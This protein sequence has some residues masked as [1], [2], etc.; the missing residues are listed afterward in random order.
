M[1]WRATLSV[2]SSVLCRPIEEQHTATCKEELLVLMVGGLR[3]DYPPW[4][5][6]FCVVPARWRS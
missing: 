3:C 5:A 1:S 2:I 4:G 6:A